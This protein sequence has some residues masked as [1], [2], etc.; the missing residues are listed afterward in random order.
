MIV[1]SDGVGQVGISKN[2]GRAGFGV[3]RN[4]ECCSW[5]RSLYWLS[6]KDLPS[7]EASPQP[8]NGKR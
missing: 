3:G 1:V 2:D 6:R 8:W 5:G 7:L 4:C